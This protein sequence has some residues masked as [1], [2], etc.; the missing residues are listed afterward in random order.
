MIVMSA[1]APFVM[2]SSLAVTWIP[3]ASRSDVICAFC[4][5]QVGDRRFG[6]QETA[7]L[8]LKHTIRFRYALVLAQVFEPRIEQ[9]GFHELFLVGS[10]LKYA[11]GI[12]AIALA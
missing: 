8:L 9:K 12:G 3:I 10:V 11:P 4:G 1:A 6:T 2:T 7:Y 5:Y